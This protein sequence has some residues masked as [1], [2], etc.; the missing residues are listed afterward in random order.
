VATAGEAKANNPWGLREQAKS[1]IRQIR[2]L[3]ASLQAEIQ[4]GAAISSLFS[5]IYHL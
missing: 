4:T 2:I 3:Q 1:H 5:L